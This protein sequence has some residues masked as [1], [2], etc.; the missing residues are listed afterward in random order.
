MYADPSK[1]WDG[2][3]E[4][5]RA[6]YGADSLPVRTGQAQPFYVGKGKARRMHAHWRDKANRSRPSTYSGRFYRYLC[7]MERAGIKPLIVRIVENLTE[8]EA[9]AEEVRSIQDIGRKNLGQGPLLN[10]TDGGEGSSGWDPPKKWRRKRSEATSG[11]N[12]PCFGKIGSAHP[13]HGKKH[14]DEYRA[15]MREISRE[16]AN[17]PSV[18]ARQRKRMSGNRNPAKRPEV[19]ELMRNKGKLR[20]ED[21]YRRA[22]LLTPQ[23]R[24]ARAQGCVTCDEIRDTLTEMV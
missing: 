9:H 6:G 11:S 18:K 21:A 24:A 14:T 8:Q 19:Q 22:L 4:E 10:M 2:S 15:R 3:T 16:R 17:M 13:H 23:L 20:T 12:N 5:Q 7:K 1:P